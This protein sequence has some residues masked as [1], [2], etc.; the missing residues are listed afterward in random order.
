MF[1]ARRSQ[2]R[3]RAAL[4]GCASLLIVATAALHPG[5]AAALGEQCSGSKIDGQGSSLQVRAQAGWTKAGEGS[6]FNGSSDASACSGSQGSKGK[7]GV[8]YGQIGSGAALHAWGADDGVFYKKGINFLGTD[9]APAGPVGEA[10]TQLANIKKAIGSDLVVA[11]VAQTAIAILAHPPALPAHAACVVSQVTNGDLEGVFSGRIT[12][13]RQ[14][15]TASDAEPGGDCDQAITRV[16]R[17]DASG[18]TYQLKH[19]LGQIEPEAL[20]CTGEAPQTWAQLQ[21]GSE[22]GS[23]NTTWPRKAACQ[24][25]EGP[26]TAL[27]AVGGTGATIEYTVANAGTITYAPL[28]Q[29]QESASKWIADVYNGVGFADP[30]AGENEANCA[31]AEYELPAGWAEGVNVD[32]SDVYGSNPTIGSGNYPICT[33]TWT[34]AP[35]NAAAV[36]G[37]KAGTTIRDYLSYVVAEEG[38]QKDLFASWYRPLPAEV[39]TAAEAAVGSIGGESEEEEGGGTGTVLCKGPAEYNEGTLDCP[40]G[41]GFTGTK[42][43]GILAPESTA[44][45]VSTFG[46]EGTITCTQAYYV[47]EFEEDG[48]STPGGGITHLDFGEKEGC[49]STFPGKPEAVLWLEAPSYDASRFVYL[50]VLPPEGAFVLAKQKGGQILMRLEGLAEACVY[51]PNFFSGQVVNGLST[52]G[53]QATWKLFEGPSELCPTTMQQSSQLRLIQ[54]GSGTGE[55]IYIAGE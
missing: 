12:N 11:P 55:P 44:T 10:G 41:Q 40:S 48:S 27:A 34:L 16:V 45:F 2:R 30:V 50:G 39:R 17:Q 5:S 21:P 9:E 24:E 29:A 28:P 6:G 35:A 46:P 7:P 18:T 32:W 36:F 43:S 26:V 8:S 23:P 15:V 42:L 13:W 49:T 31:A 53:I 51:M 1:K 38:G 47:G 33:L 54:G 4:L 14:L 25:G 20:E 19:Y 22:A 37:N 52:L 3:P